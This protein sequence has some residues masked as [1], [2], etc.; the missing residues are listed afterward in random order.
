[1]RE[2]GRSAER[3]PGRRG[4]AAAPAAA[5]A[6][7]CGAGG[8]C[9]AP[10]RAQSLG[11]AGRRALPHRV[12]LLVLTGCPPQ[13]APAA[14]C[15]PAR[16]SWSGPC[17][18]PPSP[19]LEARGESGSP[20]GTG[21]KPP[22]PGL[23]APCFLRPFPLPWICSLLSLHPDSLRPS[24]SCPPHSFSGRLGPGAGFPSLASRTRSGLLVRRPQGY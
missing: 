6:P 19:T 10:A 11:A 13:L 18:S 1:M 5:P 3:W 2:H 22:Q 24:C 15:R 16:F 21:R 12:H 7:A 14:S 8:P 4:A 23:R 20:R 17:L 9:S